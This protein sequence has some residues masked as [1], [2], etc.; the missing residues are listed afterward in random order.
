MSGDYCE[1]TCGRC[2]CPDRCQCTDVPPPEQKL[3]CA[4]LVITFAHK[5]TK[6][7]TIWPDFPFSRGIQKAIA[8]FPQLDLMHCFVSV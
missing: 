4:Q 6:T 8:L 7:I 5:R 1:T 3:A 2:Q